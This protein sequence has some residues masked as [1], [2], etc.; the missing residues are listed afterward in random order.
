[1]PFGGFGGKRE[2]MERHDPSHALTINS[3]GTFNQNALSLAAVDAVLF[4]LGQ[5]SARTQFSADRFRDQLN[6]L[7]SLGFTLSG[8]RKRQLDNLDLAAST[9]NSQYRAT[10]KQYWMFRDTKRFQ[11]LRNYFGSIC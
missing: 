3:G 9:S 6:S 8:L 10:A 5:R 4:S 1:M 2:W 7:L 11:T